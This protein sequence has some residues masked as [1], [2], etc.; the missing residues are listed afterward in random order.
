MM[1]LTSSRLG[2]KESIS[3]MKMI[4]GARSLATEKISRN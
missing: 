4:E 3:S 2:H 1:S